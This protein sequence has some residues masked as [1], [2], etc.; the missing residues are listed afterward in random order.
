MPAPS[1]IRRP[2]VL[3]LA[4]SAASPAVGQTLPDRYLAPPELGDGQAFD[5]A[6]SRTEAH[7]VV[8][9]DAPGEVT[10][11]SIG[12]DDSI[13]AWILPIAE[14]HYVPA[15]D[16][17][18]IDHLVERSPLNTTAALSMPWIALDLD[19]A[20]L[21]FLFENPFDNAVRFE[22]RDGRLAAS[23][24]H[25]F[26]DNWDE[27]EFPVTVVLGEDSPI[28]PARIYREWLIER[29][30]FVP[31]ARKIERLPKAERLLG[32]AHMYL[33]GTQAL[34]RED[35]GRKDWSTFCRR[36]ASA[37]ED[38][39]ARRVFDALDDSARK[40]VLDIPGMEWP[41]NYVKG[42][43]VW[44]VSRV[45]EDHAIPLDAFRAEFADLL[46]EVET[47]GDGYS[48]K[49]FDAF[50]QAGFDRLCLSLGGWEG[51]ST[52]PWTAER[53]DELGYL[54]GTYDSYHSI[55]RPDVTG[56]AT[57]TTAQFTWDAWEGDCIMRAD[58]SYGAGFKKRGRH[59]SPLVAMPLVEERVGRILEGTPFNATFIDCDAYGEFFDDYHPDHPATKRDDMLARLRRLSWM[60]EAHGLVVGSEGGSA[61][62]AAAIH[63]AHGMMTP[64]IGWSDPRHRD[65]DSKYYRGA[66]YPPDGPRNFVQQVPLAPEYERIHFDPRFR[67]PLYQAA[68]HDSVITTH[69]WGTHSL[70]FTEHV[71]TNTLTEMLYQVPPLYHMNLR[72]FPKHRERMVATHEF[73]S[74]LHR[75]TALMPMTSFEWLD[76]ERLVQRVVYG[77]A[78]E[79]VAN[80]SSEPAEVG[81]RVIAARSVIGGDVESDE[82]LTLTPAD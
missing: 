81:G 24:T 71:V 10:W 57:W 16:A 76:D 77:D 59:L 69:H 12:P 66:Y 54:L 46:P 51:T 30:E 55:H 62:S 60:E 34:A 42:L 23:V 15:D 3:L 14:G 33:W 40:A 29:G 18:W 58:G 61:Y 43:V 32:A 82:R 74:P 80:F 72:E 7:V 27:H 67:L 63:F 28:A 39:I 68:F 36:L 26:R 31:M 8:R 38:S 25:T 11:P 73:F 35:V 17:E 52:R 19:G 4:L 78:I 13:E 79:V 5:V 48:T 53:A 56:D 64:V 65:R 2:V 47:W 9:A 44:D 41:D 22:E 70:K 21:T 75:R 20:T 49:M 6:R 37:P 1:T 50:Q 45:L